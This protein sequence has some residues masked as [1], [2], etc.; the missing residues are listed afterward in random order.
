MVGAAAA[1]TVVMAGVPVVIAVSLLSMA[2]LPLM[3]TAPAEGPA[4]RWTVIWTEPDPPAGTVPTVQATTPFDRAPP[5]VADTK[6]V[7]GGTLSRITTP[8]RSVPPRFRQLTA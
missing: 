6:L 5:E 3:I 8:V 1:T 2:L 7:S 4:V